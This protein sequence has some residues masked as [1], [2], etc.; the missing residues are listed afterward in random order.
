MPPSTSCPAHSVTTLSVVTFI[1]NYTDL[2]LFDFSQIAGGIIGTLYMIFE[3]RVLRR[4]PL[5][6]DRIALRA[7]LAAGGGIVVGTTIGVNA[8]SDFVGT[9]DSR[10][11]F[12]RAL[13]NIQSRLGEEP[14]RQHTGHAFPRPDNEVQ[15]LADSTA[16]SEAWGDETPINRT[17]ADRPPGTVLRIRL[18]YS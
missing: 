6:V 16:N 14:L 11:A 10:P 7:C 8:F 12:I 18:Q 15:G 9:L 1:P 3:G 4:P 2:T 13:L 17:A 5:P